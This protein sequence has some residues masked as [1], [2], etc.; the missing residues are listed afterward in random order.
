MGA[1]IQRIITQMY[2]KSLLQFSIYRNVL[3]MQGRSQDL[4]SAGQAQTALSRMCGTFF[5][6][7][8]K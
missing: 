4:V 8:S 2:I 6:F 1:K 5:E 3:Q 7:S